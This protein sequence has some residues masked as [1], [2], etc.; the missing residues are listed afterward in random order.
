MPNLGNT[1]GFVSFLDFKKCGTQ[2]QSQLGDFTPTALQIIKKIIPFLCHSHQFN[3]IYQE[4]LPWVKN[5]NYFWILLD[6]DLINIKLTK[7]F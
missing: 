5:I 1:F 2:Y 3:P 7:D 4:K 6:K